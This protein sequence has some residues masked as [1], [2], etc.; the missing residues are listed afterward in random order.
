[1][2]SPRL[3]TRVDPSVKDRVERF[4][5]QSGE[6][7]QSDAVR[8]L[9]V[10]GLEAR[11]RSAGLRAYLMS[12]ASFMTAILIVSVIFILLTPFPGGVA[13]LAIAFITFVANA[14]A[15]WIDSIENHLGV[16]GS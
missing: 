11:E 15:L 16:S 3:Q 4:R 7:T 14:A 6:P 12:L 5:Q 9:V 8:R 10:E 2:S 13:V 1:M